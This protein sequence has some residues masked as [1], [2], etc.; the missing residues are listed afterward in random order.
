M[1]TSAVPVSSFMRNSCHMKPFAASILTFGLER[2]M[3]RE[4]NKLPD[5]GD[6]NPFTALLLEGVLFGRLLMN[7]S[8]PNVGAKKD[9]V[10][11]GTSPFVDVWLPTRMKNNE[12]N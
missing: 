10:L 2:P 3:W 1:C 4:N 5:F 8:D 9:E 7:D 11:S 12:E 6:N